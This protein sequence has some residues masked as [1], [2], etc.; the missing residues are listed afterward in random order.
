MNK[1]IFNIYRVLVPKPLRTVILKKTLRKKILKHFAS[2][3]ENE[4]NNEQHEVLK[5]LENNTLKI[6]P[7]A[8]YDNYS[9]ERVEVF[10]DNKTGM[11]YVL[12]DGKRLWGQTI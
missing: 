2:L 9:P 11:R 4:I 8:F 12:Q 5:F 7:Y 10:I 6:F 3:P 1:V